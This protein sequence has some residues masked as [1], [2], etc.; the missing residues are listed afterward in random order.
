LV[1]D[2]QPSRPRVVLRL[3][4]IAVLAGAGLWLLYLAA[5]NG[6]LSS[7]W[8]QQTL[9]R[10]PDKLTIAWQSAWTW[11]PGILHVRGL[12]IRGRA[13]RA[14]W[15]TTIDR[16]RLV[17]LLPSLLGRQFRLLSGDAHGGEIEVT[18][19]PPPETP[20]SAARRRPW[21]VSLEG[22]SIE[23]LHVF[24]L[25]DYELRGA[26]RATGWAQFEVAGPTQLE[27]TALSF[28]DTVVLDA[29]QIAAEALRLDGH[30]RLDPF[31]IGEDTVQDL[32]AGLTGA[33]ALETEAS[34]L[35]FLAAYLD[36]MP[37]LRLGG[38]GHLTAAI[39]TTNG[40]LAPGSRLTLQGPTVGAD[41][42][43][44]HATGEGSLVG[45]VPE[46]SSHTELSLR[47]PG[48]S[49]SRQLD[50]ALLLEGENLELLVTN[51]ST[52]IDRPARGITLA[53]R[54][55]PARV[56]DLAAFSVYLPEAAGLAIT[57]G[58]AQ[59]EANLT[60]SA[61]EKT[62]N[63]R[64]L[65]SGRQVE[66]TF[67]EVELRADL[68]LDTALA[69][70]HLE[71]G[72]IDI[73][74]THLEIDEVHTREDGQL[75]DS[76]WWGRIH[77]PD[78]RLVKVLGD[79]A[80]APTAVEAAVSADLRDTG[81]LIS[82]LQQHVPKLAWMD[83]LLT[84]HGVKARSNVSIQGPRISLADLEITGGKKG[85][86]EILGQLDLVPEDAA[87]VLYARWGKLSAAVS[88]AAGERDW[89][90]TRSRQWYDRAAPAYRARPGHATTARP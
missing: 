12:E 88:L 32:L 59:L 39:E 57:G 1:S 9:N 19:L 13:R 26:G 68:R 83:G 46:D 81:P 2:R 8:G 56:P 79:P 49:V 66:A 10:K 82:L 90:L 80:A 76:G 21:R 69:D 11:L 29:E 25:N 16:G 23:P 64:L 84:V 48:F 58:T 34:S 62:G 24:R 3:L 17:I 75:R 31:V 89:K 61:A 4:K 74:G 40:W 15:R 18:V 77:L 52:A 6:F 45:V 44:L 65:L 30:L 60:Y 71:D 42:F 33:V 63:G 22:V 36:D 38:G 54:V 7:R 70:A 43:G 87:G 20:R 14:E 27:L 41:L 37:W 73:S 67:H 78:G 85:R 53:L 28:V 51:D 86:L 47:L 72:H 5:A 35:G 55:P 50:Q